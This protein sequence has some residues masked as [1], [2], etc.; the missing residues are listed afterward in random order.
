MHQGCAA[1]AAARL[2]T[3]ARLTGPPPLALLAPADHYPHAPTAAFIGRLIVNKVHKVGEIRPGVRGVWRDDGGAQSE[4][5]L[6]PRFL[7]RA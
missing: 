7:I 5:A 1:S 4:H 2:P 3:S 6:S